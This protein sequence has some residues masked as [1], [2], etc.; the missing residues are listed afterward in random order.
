VNKLPENELA[1]LLWQYG[2]ERQSRRIARVIVQSRPLHTTLQLAEVIARAAGRGYSRIHPATRSFQA[3]RIA[4][5]Q[6]LQAVQE[7]LPQALEALAPGGRLAAIA[8]HS[9]EDRLVKQYFRLEGRDCICPPGQ[10]ICTC[11]HMARIKE[12]NRRPIEASE[13]E[14]QEN[15]RA[16]SARLRIVEKL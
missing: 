16:R 2:E 3:L 8:F 6:E 10:P 9:L 5:N 4:V 13:S 1:D 15:P 14:K 7:F 12:I 11:G